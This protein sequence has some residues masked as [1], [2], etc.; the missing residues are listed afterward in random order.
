M[1]NIWLLIGVWSVTLLIFGFGFFQVGTQ[2][3]ALTEFAMLHFLAIVIVALVAHF[4]VWTWTDRRRRI[5]ARAMLLLIA[6]AATSMEVYIILGKSGCIWPIVAFVVFYGCG[7][8]YGVI[9]NSEFKVTEWCKFC[10]RRVWVIHME[11][12]RFCLN[13]FS[14]LDKGKEEKIVSAR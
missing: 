1:R 8:I 2:K 10:R 4:R 3:K 14:D 6:V 9:E 13:C 5:W 12:G 7:V 11:N